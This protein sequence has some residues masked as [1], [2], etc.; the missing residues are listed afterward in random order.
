MWT[1]RDLVCLA[2]SAV[3]TFGLTLTLF[4]P[5]LADAVEDSPSAT[6]TISV[7][8]L[9]VGTATVSAAMDPAGRRT[10]IFTVHNLSDQNTSARFVAT[11]TVSSP[12][13][14]ESRGWGS[15]RQ[16]WHEEYAVDLQ[17]NETRSL[18][19]ILPDSAFG[20]LSNYSSN[21]FFASGVKAA[22]SSSV[23]TLATKDVTPA[24]SI[25]ALK[26]VR[27]GASGVNAVFNSMFGSQM[28]SQ[29]SSIAAT[30]S[31]QQMRPASPA[32]SVGPG[33][34]T[35]VQPLSA[36]PQATIATL[37]IPNP[38]TII[39]TTTVPP[40]SVK[41]TPA[42]LEQPIGSVVRK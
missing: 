13:P 2:A 4:Y 25:Q 15:M 34:L 33:P 27:P 42:A 32:P 3:A 24:Q 14:P 31:V 30:A 28:S 20:D 8:T 37:S 21:A 38:T 16:V 11:A 7:P 36:L 10:V 18:S 6:A 41:L 39:P 17:P 12:P 29:L 35:S 9:T 22:S 23:L 1:R 19:V 5:S 40:E 26:L